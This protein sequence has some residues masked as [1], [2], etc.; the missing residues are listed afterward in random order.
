MQTAKVETVLTRSAEECVNHEETSS[1]N[2][3]RRLSRRR[4]TRSQIS[5]KMMLGLNAYASHQR[6]MS[7]SR[8]RTSQKL[9][10]RLLTRSN[11][12]SSSSSD[13]GS[14][15][16]SD[17]STANA[18]RPNKALNKKEAH[19][20]YATGESHAYS[21]SDS[22]SD[23]HEVL[24]SHTSSIISKS[25]EQKPSVR[26]RT[27]VQNDYSSSESDS[28]IDMLQGFGVRQIQQNRKGTKKGNSHK[29][30]KRRRTR[31]KTNLK[32]RLHPSLKHKPYSSPG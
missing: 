12:A 27:N 3:S 29:S 7:E 24:A 19:S 30:F 16:S 11:Q 23:E 21:M 1:K 9:L 15:I 18:F 20:R 10:N 5:S 4:S 26:S 13:S 22:S 8:N 2:S 32:K 14:S 28:D 25:D 6:D 31:K 17:S